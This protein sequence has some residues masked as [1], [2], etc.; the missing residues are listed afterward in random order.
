MT[1]TQWIIDFEILNLVKGQS[2]LIASSDFFVPSA[3]TDFGSIDS[4][5]TRVR[6]MDPSGQRWISDIGR[7]HMDGIPSEIPSGFWSTFL[8]EFLFLPDWISNSGFDWFCFFPFSHFHPD[9]CHS[10]SSCFLLCQKVS[11]F[12]SIIDVVQ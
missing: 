6:K 7:S 4:V 11:L 8:I 2:D 3:F 9:L 5:S 12:Y 1:H 10:Y